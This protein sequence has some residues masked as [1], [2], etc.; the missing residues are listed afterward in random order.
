VSG[1]S[2]VRISEIGAKAR[3]G[4]LTGAEAD[5]SWWLI[6]QAR[7]TG[8]MNAIHYGDLQV[9]RHQFLRE[10]RDAEAARARDA[11]KDVLGGLDPK[12]ILA[13]PGALP[14]E[15]PQDPGG[16]NLKTADYAARALREG[17][18]Q[19]ALT[20]QAEG[21]MTKVHDDPARGRNL[22]LGFSVTSRTD[23]EVRSMLRQA[24]VAPSDLDEVLAG[25]REVTP[26]VV[27]RLHKL[28]VP[29]YERRAQKAIGSDAWVRLKPEARAVL[30]DMAWV[31]GNPKK[32]TEV[33]D[34]MRK[35][36]WDAASAAL[37][38]KYR[39]RRSGQLVDDHRRVNLWRL[40]LSGPRAFEKYLSKFTTK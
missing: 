36:D 6:E 9:K 33:L 21:F 17:N 35:G 14:E 30:T 1:E 19:F 27:M 12:D 7:A 34:A 38:L 5:A 3:A 4:T 29:E 28:A 32:F 26:E 40:M 24:G 20:A 11:V 25:K 23:A 37:S 13:E 16:K 15:A 31:A 22:G 39:S 10:R 18:L 8:A 2:A